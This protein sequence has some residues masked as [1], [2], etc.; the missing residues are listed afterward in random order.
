MNNFAGS[1]GNMVLRNTSNWPSRRLPAHPPSAWVIAVRFGFR[2]PR[3][4]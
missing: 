3:C 2:C 1:L 4:R